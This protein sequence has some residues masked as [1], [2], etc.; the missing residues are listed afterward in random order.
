MKATMTDGRTAATPAEHLAAAEAVV[1]KT[2]AAL[3]AARADLGA[4]RTT[5]DKERE[6][7]G[8]ASAIALLDGE[9]Q[10]SRARLDE[11]EGQI[12]D[13]ED[14]IERLAHAL[15]LAEQRAC[16]AKADVLEDDAV[17]RGEETMRRQAR[18]HVLEEELRVRQQ[19][20]DEHNLWILNEGPVKIQQLEAEAWRLRNS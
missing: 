14:L 17:R 1:D 12:P 9:T 3:T 13:A 19:E 10:P 2:A 7:Y 11:L 15:A 18:L 5:I 20:A 8:T 16:L 6:S 4:L